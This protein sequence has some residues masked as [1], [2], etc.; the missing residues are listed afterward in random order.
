MSCHSSS[1]P[2]PRAGSFNI[3]F[4]KE[5]SSPWF[6][7]DLCRLNFRG[8]LHPAHVLTP[9]TLFLPPVIPTTRDPDVHLARRGPFFPRLL[10]WFFPRVVQGVYCRFIL[11]FPSLLVN[12]LFCHLPSSDLIP[13]PLPRP[14]V[15]AF[16]P[17][18]ADWTWFSYK[19]C[20]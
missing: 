20:N 1:S 14:P 15:I 19:P 6:P 3:Y 18:I 2:S 12:S 9:L 11:P 16:G 17:M 7:S 10:P 4:L 13:F 8:K 5:L